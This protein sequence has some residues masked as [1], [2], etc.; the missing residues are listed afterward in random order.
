MPAG[1]F[2]AYDAAS[3]F[4]S[5]AGIPI[6]GWAD[7][8]FLNVVLDTDTFED[9]VGSD[10]EVTRSKSNDGRATATL[11]LMQSSPSNA[12]L[13]AAHIADKATPGGVG[14]GPFLVNDR[15]S[16]EGGVAEK[17]WIK[18]VPDMS[19]DRVVKEREWIL[20]LA[21]WVPAYT[22]I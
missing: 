3:V 12:L 13:M 14:V 11:R 15:L 22:P 21:L 9:V 18:K 10:G 20:R 2:Y 16:M 19:F 8:E 6:S 7:G 17:C 5:V 1:A 4:V